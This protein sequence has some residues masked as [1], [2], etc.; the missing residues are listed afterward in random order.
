MPV[1]LGACVSIAKPLTL[2]VLAPIDP[3]GGASSQTIGLGVGSSSTIV[4]VWPAG[5]PI[6]APDG[7]ESVTENAS[8]PSY[9]PSWTLGTPTVG[10]APPPEPPPNRPRPLPAGR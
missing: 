10:I 9:T 8:L 1:P 4:T 6:V 3:S 2:T 7:L 5:D